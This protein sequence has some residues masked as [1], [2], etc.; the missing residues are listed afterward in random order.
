MNE[1]E[2]VLAITNQKLKT[3]C[4]SEIPQSILAQMKLRKEP[5]ELWV[6]RLERS[7]RVTYKLHVA[8]AFS[9]V[10]LVYRSLLFSGKYQIAIKDGLTVTKTTT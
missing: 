8:W 6:E 9:G 5:L 1:I 10:Y 7:E 4:K 3:I 2:M